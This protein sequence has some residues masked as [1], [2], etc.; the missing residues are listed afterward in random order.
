MRNDVLVEDRLRQYG[1]RL[2]FLID[3][4]FLGLHVDFDIIDAGKRFAAR[5][6][7]DPAAE[8]V[9]GAAATAFAFAILLVVENL[10]A[11][12]VICSSAYGLSGNIDIP[13][14]VLD[15][16]R[17][18]DFLGFGGDAAGHLVVAACVRSQAILLIFG[19]FGA[20]SA[21]AGVAILISL[22]GF[23]C[24]CTAGFLLG[25]VFL[26]FLG[27][28]LEDEGAQLE[29]EIHV[30]ALAAGL[31]V[32][33]DL[34]IL[35]VDICL[36]VLAFLAEDELGDEAVEVVLQL[37]C[38]VGAVDDPAIVGRVGIRLSAKLEPKVLDDVFKLLA[39]GQVGSR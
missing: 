21:R 29:A 27:L 38:F 15:L 39:S 8:L 25:F 36:R 14:V 11:L 28:V 35:D 37:G 2:V 6:L 4:Q 5:G 10:Q 9:I 23:I 3:A 17:I 12:Q 1:Q 33:D 24:F 22:A 16:A 7:D 13:L 31:A 30:G 18:L 26:S 34:A 32:E 19:I 20:A